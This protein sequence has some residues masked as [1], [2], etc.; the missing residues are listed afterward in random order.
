MCWKI[1]CLSILPI[2]EKMSVFNNTGWCYKKS[3]KV[4][5]IT[6]AVLLHQL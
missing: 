3:E 2:N 4:F 6:V 1:V 5:S